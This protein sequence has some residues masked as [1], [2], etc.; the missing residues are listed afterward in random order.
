MSNTPDFVPMSIK[1]PTA[2]TGNLGILDFSN[3][4]KLKLIPV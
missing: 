2:T 3:G 4:I 1:S